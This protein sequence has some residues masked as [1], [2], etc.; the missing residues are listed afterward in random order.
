MDHPDTHCA[1]AVPK[2]S[3]EDYRI[4]ERGQNLR[5]SS[6][7]LRSEARDVEFFSSFCLSQKLQ[8]KENLLGGL[9]YLMANW[10]PESGVRF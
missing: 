6:P 1:I 5:M 4:Y 10:V 9:V 2:N 8:E 7:I 3:I